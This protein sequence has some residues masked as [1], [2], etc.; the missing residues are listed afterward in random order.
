MGMCRVEPRYNNTLYNKVLGIT[1]DVLQPDNS[2]VHE[3]KNSSINVF[4]QN[5]FLCKVQIV[6]ES[7][8]HRMYSCLVRR[9]PLIESYL[10]L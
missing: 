3:K 4:F 5:I 8:L 6:E 2:K 1:N 9:F 10:S 7:L